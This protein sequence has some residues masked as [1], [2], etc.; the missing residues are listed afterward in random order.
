MAYY[1]FGHT[2]YNVVLAYH[3]LHVVYAEP[4]ASADA[5]DNKDAINTHNVGTVHADSLVK[6]ENTTVTILPIVYLV[7]VVSAY[8]CNIL[9]HNAVCFCVQSKYFSVKHLLPKIHH[10]RPNFPDKG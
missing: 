3:I 8:T 7:E 10:K 4:A 9:A 5:E 2:Y 6:D 1:G